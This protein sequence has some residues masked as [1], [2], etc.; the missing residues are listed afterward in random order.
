MPFDKNCK[1][2]GGKW[3]KQLRFQRPIIPQ[4][5]A[6]P[7]C[8]KF[9]QA[10]LPSCRW[11]CTIP[12]QWDG[13]RQCLE[14]RADTE[15]EMGIFRDE[16]KQPLVPDSLPQADKFPSGSKTREEISGRGFIVK[17][18]LTK[19]CRPEIWIVQLSTSQC[20]KNVLFAPSFCLPEQQGNSAHKP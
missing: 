19:F 10:H 8:G 18:H 4:K 12:C 16:N 1:K 11:H 9:A 5:A 7:F 20:F 15:M 14:W 2:H 3:R 6:Y 13:D 17:Q